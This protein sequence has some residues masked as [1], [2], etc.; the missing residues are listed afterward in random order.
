[1]TAENELDRDMPPGMKIQVDL[2][3]EPPWTAE[4]MSEKAKRFMGW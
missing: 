2:S 4:R 1:M 3:W